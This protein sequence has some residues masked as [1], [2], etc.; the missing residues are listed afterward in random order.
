MN[1]KNIFTF[2]EPQDKLHPYINL[3]IKTWEKN[4]P[5]YKIIILNY[6]NM[7]DYVS[8]DIYDFSL[9]TK[10]R[11]MLQKDALQAAVLYKFG[12][13]FM[14]ADTIILKDITPIVDEMRYN[15]LLTFSKQL[16]FMISKPHTPVL[17]LW[18]KDIQKR[19]KSLEGKEN[20]NKTKWNFL[21]NIILNRLIDESS[22]KKIKIL[23]KRKYG[24]MPEF[25]NEN[26]N[27]TMEDNVKQYVNFWFGK[28]TDM[29]DV[30]FK[31]QRI[32]ALHNSWTPEWYKR[33][34]EKEVLENDCLL[35]RTLKYIL[36]D[37]NQS[38][39]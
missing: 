8:K 26:Q 38:F 17:G 34:S 37:S 31:N 23:D 21:G 11:F 1:D 4:L 6:L 29:K 14:D 32:I 7:F 36:N 10:L 24:F 5:D 13:I 16:A 28:D 18:M 12:G 25:M 3:C 19:I 9:L 22:N 30:F 33:L 27:N 35:S 15:E 39:S 20:I 2:W